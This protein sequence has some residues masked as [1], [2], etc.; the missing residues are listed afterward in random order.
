MGGYVGYKTARFFR[1]H[2]SPTRRFSVRVR[3]RSRTVA[4]NPTRGNR[5]KAPVTIIIRHDE[6]E[7]A[8]HHGG[9]W[10]VAYADFVTAMMAFFML[11]WLL[12]ATTEVQRTGLADY[13]APTNLFGRS[14]SGS[15]QPFGGKTPNDTGTSVSSDGMPKVMTGYHSPQQDAGDDVV[16]V[17]PP[18]PADEAKDDAT[19]PGQTSQD[20]AKAG[21]ALQPGQGQQSVVRGGDFPEVRLT[22]APGPETTA[23]APATD[24]VHREAAAIQSDAQR[25]QVALDQAGAQ[26]LAAIRRDPALQ[27]A[28]GQIIVDSVPEGLR[29]QVVDAE[30][31]PMF[32]LGSAIPT[33]RIKDLMQKVVPALAGLPNAISIAGHTDSYTFRGQDKGNWELSSDRAN[34]TRRTLVDAGL[35]DDRIRSVTGNADRDLLVPADPYNPA[36]RRITII[37]LRHAGGEQPAAQ[38]KPNRLTAAASATRLTQ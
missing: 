37:V 5:S 22:P 14:T 32:A 18:A 13:F 29:I 23:D 11:M 24:V 27:D 12:N 25:E 3:H 31:R 10:K 4:G 26:L 8:A 21:A 15:G 28:M 17:A 7:E 16:P 19:D 35:S 30:R 1:T 36:N 34:A 2:I 6:G 9:A 20:G 38:A 33:P